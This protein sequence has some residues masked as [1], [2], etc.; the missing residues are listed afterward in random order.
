[1]NKTD[2]FEVY[3]DPPSAFLAAASILR[4]GTEVH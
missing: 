1:V 2:I 3:P 4:L